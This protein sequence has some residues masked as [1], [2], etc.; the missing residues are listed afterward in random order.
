MSNPFT[1]VT[2]SGYNAGAPPDDG[3]RTAANQVSWSKHKTKIGDPLKVA[4]EAINA[5][6]LA[7]FTRAFGNDITALGTDYSVTVAD[8]GK[9]FAVTGTTT[10]TLPPVASA[11]S[12]F[13]LAIVNV[14][15]SAVTVDG[16]GA[17]TINGA[18]AVYLGPGEG[19]LLACSGVLWSAIVTRAF[20]NRVQSKSANY[21][22][23]VSD[24][25]SLILFTASA[26]LTL[27]NVAVAGNG[28]KLAV[29]ALGESVVVTVSGDAPIGGYSSAVLG[30][31]QSIELFCTGS[32][33]VMTGS[34]PEQIK[35]KTADEAVN[36]SATLQA[37]DHLAGFALAP[38]AHY[39]L[40]GFLHITTNPT[41]DFRMALVFTDAPQAVAVNTVGGSSSTPG[42]TIT[43]IVTGTEVFAYVHGYVKANA[44]TGGTVQLEW[45]QGNPDPSDTILKDG[46][47]LSL[48]R[49]A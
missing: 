47:W 11:G 48:R 32:A 25:G 20:P 23:V 10:I 38:G 7:A 27:P 35:M 31:T 26:T 14:G 3:T 18:T 15:I 39:Q 44:T 29:G 16:S 9:L 40:C 41:A 30:H 28:F 13:P 5:N 34:A 6:T 45:A 43:F 8:Q 33:W 22:V 17:E 46:S 12:I 21:P 42:A 37:D 2:V 49:V 19:M 36:N 4:I 1:S 24:V